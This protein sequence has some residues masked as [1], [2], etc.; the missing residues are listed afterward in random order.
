[1]RFLIAPRRLKLFINQIVNSDEELTKMVAEAK[2]SKNH[3][4]DKVM[5]SQ[6][7]Q[8]ELE[9]MIKDKLVDAIKVMA[10]NRQMTITKRCIND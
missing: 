1:M 5:I 2:A 7:G 10:K 6:E 4:S 9:R 8:I 3:K